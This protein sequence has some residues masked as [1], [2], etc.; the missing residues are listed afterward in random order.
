M[1][2]KPFEFLF[3]FCYFKIFHN[4]SISPQRYIP[5]Y[6]AYLLETTDPE[7]IKAKSTCKIPNWMS[8]KKNKRIDESKISFDPK[9]LQQLSETFKKVYGNDPSCGFFKSEEEIKKTI[10]DV[11]AFDPRPEYVRRKNN[12]KFVFFFF[13]FLNC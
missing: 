8:E 12:D 13:Q 5:E 6:D 1:D 9:A 4:F 7:E 3:F 2:I 10:I 11:L